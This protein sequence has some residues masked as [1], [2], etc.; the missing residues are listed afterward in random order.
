VVPSTGSSKSNPSAPIGGKLMG[1]VLIS[2]EVR[3]LNHW[4]RNNAVVNLL[5]IE[6]G[7]L[8]DDPRK[9]APS[10]LNLEHQRR[11]WNNDVMIT[12]E[13]RERLRIIV[14][15]LAQRVPR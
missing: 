10:K 4:G 13:E 3:F 5:R 15:R 2:E 6:G 14:H 11:Y 7:D 9:Y 8:Q 1:K 12:H